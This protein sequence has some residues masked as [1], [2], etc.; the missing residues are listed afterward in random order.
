[1]RT[2]VDLTPAD[3]DRLCRLIR[4][5]AADPDYEVRPEHV[6][7]EWAELAAEDAGKGK[8]HFDGQAQHRGNINA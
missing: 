5:F 2:K 3:L 1:M 7:E 8:F 6:R 4:V